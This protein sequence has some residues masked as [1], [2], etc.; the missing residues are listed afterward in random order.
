MMMMCLKHVGLSGD[1][2]LCKLCFHHVAC[3]ACFI[4]MEDEIS[5]LECVMEEFGHNM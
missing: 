2:I 5:G 1:T 4:C 3:S